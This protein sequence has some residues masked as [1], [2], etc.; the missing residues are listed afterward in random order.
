MSIWIGNIVL[1]LFY[2]IFLNKR[3]ILIRGKKTSL[4]V[5]VMFLQLL[6]L[7]T[8]ND[9]N[10]FPDT[11]AY[12]NL[13]DYVSKT[14]WLDVLQIRNHFYIKP[15]YGFI[16]FVKTLSFLFNNSTILL[17]VVGFILS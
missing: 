10:I 4:I 17:F 2:S 3:Y 16:Y 15:D 5:I 11:L 8:F 1:M 12:L 6:F 9:Y 13:F 7:Y 14:G